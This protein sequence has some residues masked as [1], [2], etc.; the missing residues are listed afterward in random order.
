MT[1][2]TA[3]AKQRDAAHCGAHR[4][5]AACGKPSSLAGLLTSF[6]SAMATTRDELE[7][8]AEAGHLLPLYRFF[9][10]FMESSSTSVK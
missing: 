3:A 8:N 5:R 10:P 7:G 1:W 6:S 9:T 2:G 4:M